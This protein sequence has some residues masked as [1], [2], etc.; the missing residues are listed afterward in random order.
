MENWMLGLFWFLLPV[1]AASGW[2]VAYSKYQRRNTKSNIPLGYIRG[3]NFLIDQK[4]DKAVDAFLDL[5]RINSDTFEVH[6]ILGN[7]FRQRGEIEKAISLHQKI[8]EKKNLN[9][10]QHASALLELGK[11]YF[12]AG[13]LD[14]AEK[15]LSK[16]VSLRIED[17]QIEAYQQLLSLYEAEQDWERAI[18]TAKRLKKLSSDE[19]HNTN[20]AHYYCELTG[21]ALADKRGDEAKKFLAKARSFDNGLL[22]TDLL[23]GDIELQHGKYTDALS[24]Y[25]KA[26]S[27]HPDFAVLLLPKMQQA[28]GNISAREFSD[29]VKRL[30]PSI[31]SIS[32]LKVYVYSLLKADLKQ[33]ADKFC[34]HLIKNKKIPIS[35]LKILLQNK[36]EKDEVNDKLLVENILESLE[37]DEEKNLTYQCSNCGFQSCKNYWH[38][39]GCG[40]W[41]LLMPRDIM[42]AELPSAQDAQPSATTG[43]TSTI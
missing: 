8:R 23:S 2:F 38:C 31:I 34:L 36:L 39:P 3:L 10:Y 13:L 22:R 24:Y 30:K 40:L 27:H 11:D 17:I 33:E 41:D 32:Y 1:A 6:I 16:A 29:Y 43:S 20:I 18:K 21:L 7:L 15:L 12:D 25:E 5:F 9:T 35:V 26:F 19:N 42:S 4:H 14:R 37:S 28:L